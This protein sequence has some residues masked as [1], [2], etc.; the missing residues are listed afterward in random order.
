MV[1]KE[2]DYRFRAS[3]ASGVKRE[4]AIEHGVDRLTPSE[5]ILDKAHVACSCG[6]MQAEARDCARVSDGAR[7][8]NEATHTP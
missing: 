3:G 6:S 5:G 2:L 4:D 1:D 7:M 8:L